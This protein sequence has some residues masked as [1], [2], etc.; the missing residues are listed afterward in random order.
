MESHHDGPSEREEKRRWQ[1]Y[2]CSSRMLISL[3]GLTTTNKKKIQHRHRR[4][5]L[6]FFLFMFFFCFLFVG[7]T[8]AVPAAATEDVEQQHLERADSGISDDVTSIKPPTP[9]TLKVLNSNFYDLFLIHNTWKWG[10]CY[11]GGFVGGDQ[12]D[13]DREFGLALHFSSA[14][15]SAGPAEGER[16]RAGQ[17]EGRS[18]GSTP[19]GSRTDRQSRYVYIIIK[20]EEEESFSHIF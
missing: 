1:H 10:I 9:T 7:L 19:S 16:F 6:V 11:V 3:P 15:I 5:D 18:L 8:T 17:A 4:L 20:K 13:H 12:R 2:Y 14:Q